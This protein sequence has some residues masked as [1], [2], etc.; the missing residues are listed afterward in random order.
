MPVDPAGFCKVKYVYT[1]TDG[2]IYPGMEGKLVGSPSTPNLQSLVDAIAAAWSTRLRAETAPHWTLGKAR[3]IWSDGTIEHLVESSLNLAGTLGSTVTF[4]RSACLVTGYQIS[5]F[6]RG[7]KPR[8]Y[9]P[10]PCRYASGSDTHYDSALVA[11]YVTAIT[12]L[13]S[14]VNAYTGT[15][16]TSFTLGAIRRHRLG[17]PIV[18][19]EF[20]AYGAVHGDTRICTQ[21]KRLGRLS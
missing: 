5:S 10:S 21:R 17:A 3:L 14:D 8:T 18:P 19:P 20:Y 9:W 16:V 13:I 7:G 6:Y 2:A 12:N 4:P 15:G 1:D 11:D